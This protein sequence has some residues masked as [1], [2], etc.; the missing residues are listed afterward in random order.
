[1]VMVVSGNKAC[2]ASCSVDLS[3][4]SFILK[5][6]GFSAE[7]KKK[8]KKLFVLCFCKRKN[9]SLSQQFTVQE[10]SAG[11]IWLCNRCVIIMQGD[12]LNTIKHSESSANFKGILLYPKCFRVSSIQCLLKKG[13][14]SLFKNGRKQLYLNTFVSFQ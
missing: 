12:H 2:D 6:S 5:V 1:M 9:R 14:H 13:G 8:K 4:V 7:S 3:L 10:Q 11:K